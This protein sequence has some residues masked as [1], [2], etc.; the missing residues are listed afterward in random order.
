MRTIENPRDSIIPLIGGVQIKRREN[1]TLGCI[2]QIANLFYG[3]TARHVLAATNKP[4]Q[5]V[6]GEVLQGGQK[7]SDLDGIIG[8]RDLD[9]AL[10]KI[11]RSFEE[12]DMVQSINGKLGKI[13]GFRAPEDGLKVRMHAGA[14]FDFSNSETNTGFISAINEA[15]NYFH[16]S[17]EGQ[18]VSEGGDSGGVW[19]EDNNSP[20][21]NIVGLHVK[22]KA[23]HS[24]AII[25]SKII[26]HLGTKGIIIDFNSDNLNG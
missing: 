26:Q 25:F 20:N 22:G 10:F 1:G 5:Q 13:V 7:I 14:S 8:D 16:I 15:N 3:L 2:F 12:I 17:K 4:D 24:K 6:R 11:D 19:I 18:C 23:Q 21:I 9:Y